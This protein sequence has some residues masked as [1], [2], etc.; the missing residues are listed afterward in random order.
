MN[1]RT[2]KIEARIRQ[3]EAQAER[4]RLQSEE[5]RVEAEYVV[6]LTVMFAR[7]LLEPADVEG[8]ERLRESLQE[9]VAAGDA[10]AQETLR[11]LADDHWWQSTVDGDST[12]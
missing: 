1:M 5:A 8:A 2:R 4:I 10:L 7:A 9:K 6:T 3:L 11:R 12:L